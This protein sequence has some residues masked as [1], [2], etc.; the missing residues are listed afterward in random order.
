M[1]VQ[2]W[3]LYDPIDD[4]TLVLHM[5]PPEV[6]DHEGGSRNFTFE[7]TCAPDGRTVIFE[8][9]EEV[10]RLDWDGKCRVASD[11]TNLVAWRLKR[12]QIRVTDDLGR[13]VW[14][15]IQSISGRR[16]VK[17]GL[18]YYREYQLKAVVLNVPG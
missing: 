16:K 15:L 14:V 13:Q 4:E 17:G 9:Q 8:G 2:R 6:D 1:P 10:K 7:E 18:P 3:E 5:N 12:H 11:W